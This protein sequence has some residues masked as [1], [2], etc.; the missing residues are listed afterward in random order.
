MYLVSSSVETSAIIAHI[1]HITKINIT[2]YKTHFS[3]L[4]HGPFFSAGL[5][6]AKVQ[7]FGSSSSVSYLSY[8]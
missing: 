4:S 7:H 5:G 3:Y 6:I 2:K 1:I 8:Y